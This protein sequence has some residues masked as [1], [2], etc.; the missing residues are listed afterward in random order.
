MVPELLG[1]VPPLGV[2]VG[3]GV[4]ESVGVLEVLEVAPPLGVGVGECVIDPLGD[5]VWDAVPERDGVYDGVGVCEF[6]VE[7]LGVAPPLEVGVPDP[8]GDIA[9]VEVAVP[10]GVEVLESVCD[11]LR[12]TVPD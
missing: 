4:S 8:V 7:L 11:A 9:C 1:V 5:I 2:G 10:E 12:V 3:D 6:T